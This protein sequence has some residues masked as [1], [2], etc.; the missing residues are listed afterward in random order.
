MTL[1]E[2]ILRLQ[3]IQQSL[4]Q[5]SLEQNKNTL[6]QSIPLLEE[7]TELRKKILQ[8]LTEIENKLITLSSDDKVKDNN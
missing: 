7:A 8:Q 4:G 6:S 3:E 2:M 5:D 1:E